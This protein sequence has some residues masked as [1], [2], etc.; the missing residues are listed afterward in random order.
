MLISRFSAYDPERSLG[1]TDRAMAAWYHP[2]HCMKWPQPE[3]SHGRRKFL[4]TLGGAVAACVAINRHVVGRIREHEI[5]LRTLHEGV[6]CEFIPRI[7]AI[8]AVSTEQPQVSALC[9]GRLSR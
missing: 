5:R 1:R 7:A 4:A 2:S 3:G 8:K 9:N 6:V